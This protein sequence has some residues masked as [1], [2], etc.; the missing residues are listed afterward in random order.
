MRNARFSTDEHNKSLGEKG[1]N[2]K[3]GSQVVAGN[4]ASAQFTPGYPLR[5]FPFRSSWSRRYF[6]AAN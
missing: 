4:L 3:K 6:V 5:S 1:G 2:K